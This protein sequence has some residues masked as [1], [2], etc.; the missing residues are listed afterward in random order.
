MAFLWVRIDQKLIHGQVS[1]GWVPHLQIDTVIVSDQDMVDDCWSQQVMSLGLPDEIKA[2][3]FTTPLL[4]GKLLAQKEIAE[5]RVLVL[6]KT[7]EDFLESMAAGHEFKS[8]NLG[9]QAAPP[10][11]VAVQLSDSFFVRPATLDALG[12]FQKKGLDV[13]IQA[14]PSAKVTIWQP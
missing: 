8:L 11:G 10:D 5:R 13:S 1:V 3:H 6:F 14:T 4:L 9:N 12:N 7:L 2:T